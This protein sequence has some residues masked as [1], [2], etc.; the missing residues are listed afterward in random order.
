MI[1]KSSKRQDYKVLQYF[2]FN[3]KRIYEQV[4]ARLN[5]KFALP[6]VKKSDYDYRF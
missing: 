4:R 2:S 3:E 5:K 1:G 6:V